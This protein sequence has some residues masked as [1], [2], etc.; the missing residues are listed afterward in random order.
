MYLFLNFT[1][2]IFHDCYTDMQVLCRFL[3]DYVSQRV[4]NDLR[5]IYSSYSE[6]GFIGIT[7]KKNGFCNKCL[8]WLHEG[9]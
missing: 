1:T 9:F 6:F 2:D 4:L 3:G 5:E 7:F 8:H